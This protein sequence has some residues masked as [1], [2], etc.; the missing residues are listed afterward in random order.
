MSLEIA[1]FIVRPSFIAQSIGNQILHIYMLLKQQ[2]TGQNK[3]Y[4]DI[5]NLGIPNIWFL[6]RN[7]LYEK[8]IP[9]TLFKIAAVNEV[10]H[11]P[12]YE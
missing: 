8:L 1:I 7:V 3:S 4:N 11:I 10:N 2:L 12:K 9:A 5:R 6:I